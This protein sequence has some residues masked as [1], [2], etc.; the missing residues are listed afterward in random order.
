M[1]PFINS[2]SLF[3]KITIEQYSKF[4]HS[5]LCLLIG[6]EYEINYSYGLHHEVMPLTC[7]SLYTDFSKIHDFRHILKLNR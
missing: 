1:K 4:C 7:N 5:L 6:F 2:L 3:S